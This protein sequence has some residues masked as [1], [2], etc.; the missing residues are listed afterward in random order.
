MQINSFDCSLNGL[1]ARFCFKSACIASLFGCVLNWWISFWTAFLRMWSCHWTAAWGNPWILKYISPRQLSLYVP[2]SQ[3]S[4]W[5]LEWSKG[6][7]ASELVVSWRSICKF[8]FSAILCG[9]VGDWYVLLYNSSPDFL[10][11]TFS[12]HIAQV[13]CCKGWSR[14][15][16]FDRTA[17]LYSE[18]PSNYTNTLCFE[19]FSNCVCTLQSWA[20]SRR[21]PFLDNDRWTL[22]SRP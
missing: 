14:L 22:G 15:I 11:T 1:N 17:I 7:L 8:G 4:L 5:L 12:M 2:P 6:V 9:P 3:S 16:A 21:N 20:S 10:I 18:Q 19:V 13:K